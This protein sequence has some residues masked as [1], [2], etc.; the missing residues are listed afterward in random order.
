VSQFSF[1]VI[2]GSG[3][4]SLLGDK[5]PLRARLGPAKTPFGPSQPLSVVEAAGCQFLFLPRPGERGYEL[6]A[7]WV[8][9]RANIYALKDRGVERIISWS[10]PGAID[11]ALQLGQYLLPDDLLDDTRGR[12]SSFFKGTGLGFLRQNPVFCPELRK[13]AIA[14][15]ETMGLPFR[16][17]GTYVCTQGPRLETPAEIRKFASWGAQLV[18]MTLA[19]EVFLAKELEMC[20][21]AVCYVSNYAEGVL[22]R[23]FRPGELFGGLNSAEEE[24]RVDAAVQR[25]PDLLAVLAASLAA[26]PRACACGEAM[27]RY[28]RAGLITGEWRDWLGE[29]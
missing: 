14:C 5:L 25:L 8:N 1:A 27:A 11:P 4:H 24:A 7:P 3:A 23:P 12:E 2:G 19:P 26:A 6:A 22:D 9:Y 17:A 29:A 28:R 21:A 15:L 13:H 16:G 18:G 10:G 20:Y